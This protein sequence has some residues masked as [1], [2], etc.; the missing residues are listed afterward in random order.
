MKYAG[1]YFLALRAVGNLPP[2]YFIARACQSC[3]SCESLSVT[4]FN[5]KQAWFERIIQPHIHVRLSSS[6]PTRLCQRQC[7][8]PRLSAGQTNSSDTTP[9]ASRLAPAQM[10]GGNSKT[11]QSPLQSG[12]AIAHFQHRYA[13]QSRILDLLY[14]SQ[15]SDPPK[16]K[17]LP[18][19][20]PHWPCVR[21][22]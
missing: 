9:G 18:L 19:S 22:E 14:S 3:E 15:V 6:S 16:E 7:D 10:I 12:H 8:E 21:L 2:D 4:S 20:A 13:Q 11:H 5:K 17:I 1:G